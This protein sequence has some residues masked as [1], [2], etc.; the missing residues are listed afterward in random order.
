MMSVRME[1]ALTAVTRIIETIGL[2]VRSMFESCRLVPAWRDGLRERPRR[3]AGERGG[4]RRLGQADPF[5]GLCSLWLPAN[6]DSCD[7]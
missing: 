7:M 1:A 3:F 4:F 5:G 6:R 2:G